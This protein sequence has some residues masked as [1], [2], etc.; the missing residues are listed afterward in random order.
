MSISRMVPPLE[1][2]RAASR[3]SLQSFELARLNHAA[4]LK[5]EIAVLIDQWIQERSEATLARWMLDHHESLH[6]LP[7]SVP[8]AI[9][10]FSEPDVDPLPDSPIPRAVVI[11][12]TPRFNGVQHSIPGP[13]ARKAHKQKA[14]A[15][16]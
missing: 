2:L 6:D 14:P 13:I 11:R 5:R 15:A 9:A 10:S 3:T 7:P 1:Y 4:N 12:A 16:S 8:E